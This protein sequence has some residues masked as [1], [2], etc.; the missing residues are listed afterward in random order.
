LGLS[1]VFGIVKQSGG[2]IWVYSEPGVGTTFKVYL[3]RAEEALLQP[4]P[5]AIAQTDSC[6][7]SETVLVV[8]DEEAVRMLV[9]RVLESNGYRVLEARHGAEALVVC[10][11][12]KEPIHLL[13]TDVIMPEMG[14]RQLAERVSDQ[15][16]ETKILFMSGYTDN[17]ILHHGVLKS[18]TNF[19]QKPFTPATVLRK[20][21][22]VLDGVPSGGSAG[23]Q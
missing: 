12:H 5:A 17:A 22:A 2:H 3:P 15:R 4:E 8:E 10:D 9:C 18:G 13:M 23:S 14:G 20:V 19:L 11:E 6:Q 16:P 1:T 21:R 7:G